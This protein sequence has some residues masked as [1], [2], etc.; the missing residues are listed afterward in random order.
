MACEVSVPAN[1]SD[2]LA[3]SASSTGHGVPNAHAVPRCIPGAHTGCSTPH[4]IRWRV[5]SAAA[6]APNSR[7]PRIG[8]CAR[9]APPRSAWRRPIRGLF[10]AGVKVTVNSDVVLVFGNRV[11]EDFSRCISAAELDRTRMNGLRD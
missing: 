9:H 4:G 8:C 2:F 5:F 7:L 6:A 11:S 1:T 10:D 3:K